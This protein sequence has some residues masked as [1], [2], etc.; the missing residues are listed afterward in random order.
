MDRKDYGELVGHVCVDS[1]QIMV[2]D[3]CYVKGW[4]DGDAFPGINLSRQDERGDI[5]E[6]SAAYLAGKYTPQND[7]ESAC[8]A[9]MSEQRAGPCFG[10]TPQQASAVATSSGF[11]DGTYPVYIQ[12]S[13]EGAWGKRVAALTVVFIPEQ[14]P[15]D[16]CGYRDCTG[17]EPCVECGWENCDGDCLND[18]HYDEK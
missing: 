9:T 3:P 1:G 14:V 11:G 8:L 12:Y 2:V 5:E 6:R 7:Y 15:C 17:C 18:E 13:A 16:Y 4:K 10:D